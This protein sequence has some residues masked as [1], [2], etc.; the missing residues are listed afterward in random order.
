MENHP[1]PP[2]LGG[3][4]LSGYPYSNLSTGGPGRLSTSQRRQSRAREP[5]PE[6]E[7]QLKQLRRGS[8]LQEPRV[9]TGVGAS[10]F[11]WL[12]VL[13]HTSLP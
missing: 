12:D 4:K 5:R 2:N 1:Y 6:A 7:R 13:D 11:P 8:S 3:R 9:W 10:D